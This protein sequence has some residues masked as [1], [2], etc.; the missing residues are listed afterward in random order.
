MN[1][2]KLL[3]FDSWTGG[4]HHIESLVDPLAAVGVDVKLVH[5][6]SWGNDARRAKEDAI[7]RLRVHDISYYGSNSFEKVLDVEKPDAVILLSTAT[8]AHRAFLRYAH[9]RGIPSLHQ[10]H[11]LMSVQVTEDE[12]GSVKANKLAYARLVISML[13]K[14]ATRT[15]P[16]YIRAMLKTRASAADWRRMMTDT[17][18]LAT[19]KPIWQP[20]VAPDARTTKCAVYVGADREHATRVYGLAPRDVVAVG[21]P[22]LMRFGIRAEHIGARAAPG[23]APSP[24]MMYIDTGLVTFGLTF[25]DVPAFVKHLKLTASALDQ[26]GYSMCFKPHPAHD[27][28]QL[29]RLLEGSGIELVAN[30]QF[31]PTLLQC[32]ACIVEVSSITLVPAVIGLPM[33]LA[34]YNELRQLRYG[35]FLLSYPR[36][37]LLEDLKDVTNLLR[38]DAER[39]DVAGLAEWIEANGGPQPADRMPERVATLILDMIEENRAAPM[40]RSA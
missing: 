12:E 2:Y 28:P 30:D 39:L 5:L 17:L 24:K 21:N 22:D 8:F 18:K 25:T 9:E 29:A 20:N 11:S 27:R 7:G 14:L 1:R 40:R 13:Y 23:P 32:A 4:A 3:A 36:S 26:Q 6:G 34:N 35:K 19:G 38:Q 10:Y 31:L 15:Y 37:Y 33:L 16:C